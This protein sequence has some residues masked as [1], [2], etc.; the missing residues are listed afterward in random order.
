MSQG[1]DMH[2]VF[3]P[4][5]LLEGE[6]HQGPVRRAAGDLLEAE[7]GEDRGDADEALA[8]A[9]RLLRLDGADIDGG[10]A[11]RP[12]IGDRCRRETP[13]QPALAIARADEETAGGTEL[14]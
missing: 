12:R 9:Q 11:L 6:P 2:T 8:P 7:R 5:S 13:R 14:R 3:S 10:G 1:G 4:S